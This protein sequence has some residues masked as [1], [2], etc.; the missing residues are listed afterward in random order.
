M[1]PYGRTGYR[2]RLERKVRR[3]PK[4][5]ECGFEWPDHKHYEED[6]LRAE[7]KKLRGALQDVAN[8]NTGIEPSLYAYAV[9]NP[10]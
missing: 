4:C 6:Q 7:I 3:M 1:E 10:D 2:V 9:L 5:R 8:E